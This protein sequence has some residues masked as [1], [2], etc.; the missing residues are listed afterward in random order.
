MLWNDMNK[1]QR[2][3]AIKGLLASEPKLRD[4]D[5]ADRLGTSRDSIS[6]HIR[7]NQ[8]PR[9]LSGGDKRRKSPIVVRNFTF[10]RPTSPVPT[11]PKDVKA[12]AFEPLPGAPAPKALHELQH[13]ECHWPVG[14]GFCGCHTDTNRY[15]PKHTKMSGRMVPRLVIA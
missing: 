2:V 3:G 8:I 15:C 7:E 14:E 4:Q 6:W 5:L 1:A 13:G 10:G 9:P 12:S 11:L